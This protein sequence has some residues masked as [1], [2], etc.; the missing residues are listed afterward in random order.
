VD[1]AQREKAQS[2]VDQFLLKWDERGVHY[3]LVRVGSAIARDHTGVWR[4]LVTY[5]LPLHKT[6]QGNHNGFAEYDGLKI[7]SGIAT[8]DEA[9]GILRNVLASSLLGFP[10]LTTVPFE[11][12]S[13]H[14]HWYPSPDARLPVMF[15]FDELKIYSGE[16]LQLDQGH[17]LLYAKDYP[18]FPGIKDAIHGYL[19]TRLGDS[20]LE[21]CIYV[22]APDYRGRIWQLKL[23]TKGVTAVIQSLST[24]N[25]EDLV[26]KMYVEMVEGIT[27]HGEPS[28]ENGIATLPTNGFPERVLVALLSR[29][30]G[31]LIDYKDTQ[32]GFRTG[33]TVESTEED[34]RNVAVA[35]ESQTLEYKEV[36]PKGPELAREV[37]AFANQEGGRILCGVTDDGRIVGCS[38]PAKLHDHIAKLIRSFCEPQPTISVEVVDVDD[39]KIIVITVEEGSDKPYNVK[40]QG[41]YIRTL[42]ESRIATRY[43]LDQMQRKGNDLTV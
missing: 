32:F 7:A 35:G 4:N 5:L 42:T 22:L 27:S 38:F 19:D 1:K 30:T 36:L 26:V 2:A 23:S 41:I 15:S 39:K 12:R 18:I 21:G 25:T 40:D 6:D 31:E 33:I 16:T 20:S 17:R 8:L 28:I 13:V 34:I 10:R 29:S 9:R 14:D 3:G 11:V 43:E 37:V 24:S